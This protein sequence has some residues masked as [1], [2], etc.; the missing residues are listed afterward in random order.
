MGAVTILGR[1]GCGACI[2]TKRALDLAG[3]GYVVVDVDESE[4]AAQIAQEVAG[5]LGR[6][7]L[8]IVLCDDGTRWSGLRLDRIADVVRMA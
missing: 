5:E 7:E 6:T 3:I 1:V 4:D 8:P 2:F